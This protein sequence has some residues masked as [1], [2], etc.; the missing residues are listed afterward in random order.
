MKSLTFFALVVSPVSL[1]SD[2]LL[3]PYVRVRFIILRKIILLAQ[4]WVHTRITDFI[5]HTY[6][7]RA[8]AV[9]LSPSE[10][11]RFA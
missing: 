2:L 10:S 9:I 7:R 4:K 1:V 5:D 8:A 3:H 6:R 11:V